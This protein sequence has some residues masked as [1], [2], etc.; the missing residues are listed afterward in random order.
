[1]L[2]V[3]VLAWAGLV[4]AV[5]P[6]GEVTLPLPTYEEMVRAAHPGG[7]QDAPAPARSSV[8]EASYEVTADGS[9]ARVRMTAVV[10]VLESRGVEEPLLDGRAALVA[11]TVDG[12]P[13]GVLL[14]EE[15]YAVLV[16]P[17][18]HTVVMEVVVPVASEG[19]SE[20]SV[21]VPEAQAARLTADLPGAPL[22]VTVDGV[23]HAQVRAAGRRTTVRAALPVLSELRMSWVR[24]GPEED[25]E[26][27]EEPSPAASTPGK[28]RAVVLHHLGVDE[29]VLRGTVRVTLTIQKGTRAQAVV[30]LPVNVE[31]LD[32]QTNDLRDWNAAVAGDRKQVTVNFKYGRTGEVVLTVRYER[33][34]KDGS[35]RTTFEVPEVVVADTDGERGFLGVETAPGVEVELSRAEG[36]E[37][38]DG[39][40]L[41]P[42][43]WSMGTTPLVLGVKYLEHPVRVMLTT[44]QRAKV[45]VADTTI[46]RATFETVVNQQ[47]RAV[48][49]VNYDVRNHQRQYLEVVLP[50]GTEVLSCFVHGKAVRPARGDADTLFIPL[51]RSTASEGGGAS[52]PVELVIAQETGSLWPLSRLALTMPS[53]AVQA[54]DLGWTVYVPSTHLGLSFGGNFT[55]RE[56]P[57]SPVRWLSGLAGR[58]AT[59]WAGG[60]QREVL[61]GYD[62]SQGVKARFATKQ[63]EAQ[64]AS[65]VRVSRPRVG[66]VYDLRANLLRS[67]A[68]RVSVLLANREGVLN[69]S[70]LST[71]LA[72]AG[73]LL[74]AQRRRLREVAAM[75]GGPPSVLDPERAPFTWGWYLVGAAA[76]LALLTGLYVS[77]VVTSGLLAL[78][79]YPAWRLVTTLKDLLRPQARKLGFLPYALAWGA[80]LVAFVVAAGAESPVVTALMLLLAWAL[81]WWAR[82]WLKP[83]SSTTSPPSGN[84]VSPVS[85]ASAAGGAS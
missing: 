71:L 17:G 21:V 61:E 37:P 55:L 6:Q 15:R 31:V 58:A 83:K 43:L 81:A 80:L 13:A 27:A 52:F 63:V 4:S 64:V 22:A 47:G 36:A 38:L 28:A 82:S 57:R 39:R 60:L 53:T 66:R 3:S 5:P 26:P 68:P 49:A 34:L 56:D 23:S 12:K 45:P 48:S 75:P 40:D 8:R 51:D 24:Q 10:D 46:D 69:A 67:E 1:M 41:P 74:L 32:V 25:P 84:P 30:S 44:S 85:S 72:L 16:A 73:A 33:P 7:L 29:A 76:P 59:A 18:T 50:R 19:P 54:M 70:R 79:A 78:L 42:D 77:S 2:G 65:A 11:C 35:E 9:Q 14:R 20:L 62:Y